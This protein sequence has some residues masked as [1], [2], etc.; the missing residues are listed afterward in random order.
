[1]GPSQVRARSPVQAD[2]E[3]D[4]AKVPH[5]LDG[6]EGLGRGPLRG[7]GPLKHQPVQS[8]DNSVESALLTRKMP[9][10]SRDGSCLWRAL[11]SREAFFSQT[12]G[13]LTNLGV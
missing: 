13:F 9:L 2:G 7:G 3:V 1:M 10:F 5:D 6:E 4:V 12:I 8:G 11:E